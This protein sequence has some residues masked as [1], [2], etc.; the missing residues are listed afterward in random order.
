MLRAVLRPEQ[1]AEM[2]HRG[3]Q[4]VSEGAEATEIL[5]AALRNAVPEQS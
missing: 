2:A 4:I 1:A 3:W 5:V